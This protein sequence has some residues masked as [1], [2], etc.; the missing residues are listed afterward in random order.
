MVLY[1][2]AG[3]RKYKTKKKAK[4]RG[5]PHPR[6]NSIQT[7]SQQHTNKAVE[8]PKIA[9][10]APHKPHTPYR[11]KKGR[12]RKSTANII[13]PRT[14][15]CTQSSLKNQTEIKPNQTL[16][17][18]EPS[19]TNKPNTLYINTLTPKTSL[20]H[21]IRFVL[22]PVRMSHST[23]STSWLCRDFFTSIIR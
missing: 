22:C 20:I 13:K 14:H 3:T 11:H 9:P 8:T 15:R 2:S 12:R 1:Q 23:N 16:R 7:P 17:F 19:T 6:T 10:R 21:Y 18:T 4:I 5:L